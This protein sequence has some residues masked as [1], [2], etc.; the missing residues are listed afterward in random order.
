VLGARAGG[1]WAA[2]AAQY[3]KKPAAASIISAGA[4]SGEH[5]TSGSDAQLKDDKSGVRAATPAWRAAHCAAWK[6]KQ[7]RLRAK[8]ETKK[9]SAAAL[10]SRGWPGW[11]IITCQACKIIRS[12]WQASRRRRFA[13]PAAKQIASDRRDCFAACAYLCTSAHRSCAS[14]PHLSPSWCGISGCGRRH[15]LAKTG[16]CSA[17]GGLGGINIINKLVW[18]ALR[19]WMLG[20]Y[21]YAVWRV[22]NQQYASNAIASNRR[23]EAN[24]AA[25][26]RLSK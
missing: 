21:L 24:V 10:A 26:W 15:T 2:A 14:H 20:V 4:I 9:A 6:G 25:I 19:I 7:L 13:S 8:A 3:G 11:R 18:M 22:C 16:V 1:A 17:N 12:I 23:S 5:Q